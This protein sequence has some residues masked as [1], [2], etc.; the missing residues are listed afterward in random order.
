[1]RIVLLFVLFISSLFASDPY[2]NIT[3]FTLDNG[4]SV[5]LYPDNKAKNIQIIVDVKVGRKVENRENAGLSHLVE[6]IVFRDQR[7]KDKD[8]LN[9]FKD[10]GATYVNGYTKLYK[11]QYLTT[12]SADKSYWIVEQ[13]A[14]M[15][16]DKNVTNEDLKSERGAL[17][18]E[19]GEVTW[20]DKYVPSFWNLFVNIKHV[21]PPLENFYKD[22]FSI[23]V[24][25]EERKYTPKSLYRQN[26]QKF[27]LQEVMKHYDDY[28]YPSNMILNITGN[29]DLNQMKNTIE[30][31]FGRFTKSSGKTIEKKHRKV[32]I[33]NQKPYER[34]D[35]SLD[36][37]SASVGAKFISNDP[38]KIIILD[39]Y[40]KD[41]GNR[42]N[43]V[44]RN[45]NGE[46]YGVF[47]Y[48]SQ[49]HNAAVAFIN[50]NAPHSAFDKNIEYVKNQI[51][52]ESNGELTDKEIKEA[53]KASKVEYSAIEHDTDSLMDMI[54]NY[55][56]F[57]K[58]FDET[59][60]PYE[61]LNSITPQEF[62]SVVKE[63]FVSP[64]YYQ[65]LYRDYYLFPYD[66]VIFFSFLLLL[67]LY[68][69]YRLF[70]IRIDR[71]NIRMQRRLT[72]LFLSVLMIFSSIIFAGILTAWLVY[73]VLKVLPIS[74]LWVNGYDMPTSYIVYLIDF[75]FSLLITYIVIKLFFNWLYIKL[76]VTE[77]SLILSG[78]KNKY[79]K[80]QD[81]KSFEI[82]PWKLSLWREIHGMS[83]LFWKPLLKVTSNHN[84]VVYLRANNVEH[85]KYDL[86]SI[87]FQEDKKRRIFG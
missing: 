51:Q 47:G 5:Y 18:V 36:E 86:E 59:K 17:Q 49:Y 73:F 72:G 48:T 87:I 56:N 32:A 54:F 61:I 27:T 44:F 67:T 15:L 3:H 82:V 12:I 57:N 84:D 22:E 70:S 77:H 11:T 66:F 23:D 50:F 62:K 19:I 80:H 40:V 85:L 25:D 58:M 29:F 41:L 33:L 10:E 21:L 60:T 78:V 45:K 76:Y 28:Y 13:F 35:I 52:K 75:A 14:Q 6:H 20:V 34:Y 8:Y 2:K 43:K 7:V 31:S 39:S 9:L 74:Y 63:T 81:I 4:L 24:K 65:K 53:L 1:M 26:N 42:L 30:N 68:V 79:I 37:N 71:R 46:S 55:Q 38:K 64:N 69:V 83:L 16:L